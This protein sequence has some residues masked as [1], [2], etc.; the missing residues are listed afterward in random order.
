MN[1][2]SHIN[3]PSVFLL[4]WI[5][6]NAISLGVGLTAG[7]WLGPQ[8]NGLVGWRLAVAIISIEC[9]GLIWL[10][11]GLIL[12]RIRSGHLLDI[13]G[14]VAWLSG[15]WV[16]ILSEIFGVFGKPSTGGDQI[17]TWTNGPFLSYYLGALG[18]MIFWL[19][20]TQVARRPRLAVSQPNRWGCFF[21]VGG[22]LLAFFLWS[23]S[24]ILG[25]AVGGAV[26]KACGQAFG[27]C[28]VGLTVGTLV[29]VLT[30]MAI[31]RLS[32]GTFSAR[33]AIVEREE[34]KGL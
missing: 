16:V 11:R 23:L 5:A 9:E 32:P 26:T 12:K 24:L 10:A 34:K 1:Y 30:G 28:A 2:P 17:L 31:A 13:V 20:R 7:E 21:R 19:I 4:A 27:A 33:S 14:I 15:E 22:S 6:V 29:G 18:W 8:L 3:K 25:F